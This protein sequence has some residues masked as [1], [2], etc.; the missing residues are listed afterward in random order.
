MESFV[1][2]RGFESF[3]FHV[4]M[5]SF[6]DEARRKTFVP[7]WRQK[8]TSR[9]DLVPLSFLSS[10]VHLPAFFFFVVVVEIDNDGYLLVLTTRR[11]DRSDSKLRTHGFLMLC[12]GNGLLWLDSH[13]HHDF[14]NEVLEQQHFPGR[15]IP[16]SNGFSQRER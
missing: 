14:P 6:Q 5:E 16:V 4:P 12:I 7:S 3:F 1:W 9:Y 10:W 13:E 2:T 11:K 8:P 15:E